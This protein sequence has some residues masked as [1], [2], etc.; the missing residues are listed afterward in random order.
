MK[1]LN[2]KRKEAEEPTMTAKLANR[3]LDHLMTALESVIGVQGDNAI[4]QK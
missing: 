3:L 4:R 2:I 1:Y